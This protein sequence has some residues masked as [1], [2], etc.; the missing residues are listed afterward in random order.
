MAYRIETNLFDFLDE[1]E[2]G[3]LNRLVALLELLPAESLLEAMEADRECHKFRCPAKT[4]GLECR[5]FQECNAGL[6]QGRTVRVACEGRWRTLP[7][8]PVDSP[9]WERIYKGRTSVER[10]FGR[11]KGPLGLEELP[12][13]SKAGVTL[14]VTMGLLVLV[15]LAVCRVRQGETRNLGKIRAA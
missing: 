14:R 10:A 12:V 15:A 9:K 2:L 1:R 7:P 8:L 11:L 3:D 6:S 13:R 5:R 4:H